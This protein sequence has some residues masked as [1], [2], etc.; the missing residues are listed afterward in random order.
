[1][2]NHPL[3][4]TATTRWHCCAKYV[5]GPDNRAPTGNIPNR[6]WRPTCE[7]QA[8]VDLGGTVLEATTFW[9]G[10]GLQLG[11]ADRAT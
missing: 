7:R 4:K 10:H 8:A 2:K 9:S 1:M 3:N 11:N 5:A 6:P